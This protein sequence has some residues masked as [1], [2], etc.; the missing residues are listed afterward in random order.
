MILYGNHVLTLK[1]SFEGCDGLFCHPCLSCSGEGLVAIGWETFVFGVW[2][3][4]SSF[5]AP[6]SVET[7]QAEES[8]TVGR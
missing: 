5:P 6:D 7:I 4:S 1:P 8:P 2:E 3:M